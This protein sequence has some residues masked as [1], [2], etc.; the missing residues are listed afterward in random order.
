[1]GNKTAVVCVVL[2]FLSIWFISIAIAIFP[3]AE[4][5]TETK[6]SYGYQ[7]FMF[8]TSE[9][10]NSSNSEFKVVV[11]GFDFESGKVNCS[12]IVH[13]YVTNISTDENVFFLLQ[14]PHNITNISV[15]YL[16]WQPNFTSFPNQ[17]VSYILVEIPKAD[18]EPTFKFDYL[19]S[20]GFDFTIEHAISKIDFYTYDVNLLFETGFHHS[21][22]SSEIEDVVKDIQELYFFWTSRTFLHVERP[23]NYRF[24]QMLP[25]PQR[26]DYWGGNPTFRWDIKSLT[27][28]RNEIPIILSIENLML[29]EL[30]TSRSSISF[31]FL[32][33][34]I[35]LLISSFFEMFKI[36]NTKPKD[37]LKSLSFW[38]VLTVMS[39]ILIIV[40][41][42]I[43]LWLKININPFNMFEL[44]NMFGFEELF[45]VLVLIGVILLSF[46]LFRYVLNLHRKYDRI[47]FIFGDIIFIVFYLFI[48][49]T[50]FDVFLSAVPELVSSLV[51]SELTLVLAWIEL[52]KRPE[53][54]MSSLAPIIFGNDRG[55]KFVVYKTGFENEAPKPSKFL[56]I[57]EVTPDNLKFD[58]F[59]FSVDLANIGFEEIMVHDYVMY[60]DDKR[61]NAI[62]LGN[63]PYDERLRLITQQRHAEDLPS[64]GIT[65][66]GFHKLKVVFSGMT[67]NCSTELWFFLSKDF[68]QMRYVELAPYHRLFLS[69]IKNKLTIKN[70]KL[71][72]QFE[73]N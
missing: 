35:P 62:P 46:F 36:K 38:V 31:L 56:K 11:S 30:Y 25:L 12:I 14:V 53:L 2:I 17:N 72:G 64:L 47:F 57:K 48:G 5:F 34:G 63:P 41:N 51:I 54:K 49:F 18:P 45:S 20:F 9:E 66:S 1:M 70:E 42:N 23:E 52:S 6:V 40:S 15:R 69:L 13:P 32:G 16:N 73:T 8:G 26:P 33:I 59:S 7:G 29:K 10:L 19:G 60:I 24:I 39:I 27:S 21:S 28:E 3:I 37:L 67:V 71:E 68:K 50:P 43:F 55:T 61:Q 65:T 58:D 22:G 4:T 44:T